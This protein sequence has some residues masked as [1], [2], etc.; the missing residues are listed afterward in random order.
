MLLIKTFSSTLPYEVVEEYSYQRDS[1]SVFIKT[2]REQ[3]MMD[4]RNGYV[5]FT[6][7]HSKHMFSGVI[8]AM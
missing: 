6:I 3:D 2:H 7:P 8:K 5:V 4:I 1:N